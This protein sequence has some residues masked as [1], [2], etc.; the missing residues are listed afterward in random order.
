[1]GGAAM[2]IVYYLYHLKVC[3]PLGWLEYSPT[4]EAKSPAFLITL[5]FSC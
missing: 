5:S 3:F 4:H 2:L 1:M